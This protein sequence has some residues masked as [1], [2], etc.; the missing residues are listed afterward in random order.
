MSAVTIEL[1]KNT[2]YSIL[3]EL[4]QLPRPL[5]HAMHQLVAALDPILDLSLDSSSTNLTRNMDHKNFSESSRPPGGKKR[6]VSS[7][8]RLRPPK[9]SRNDASYVKIGSA[10]VPAVL[11]ESNEDPQ[12]QVSLLRKDSHTLN[13]GNGESDSATLC[14]LL[15]LSD[16]SDVESEEGYTEGDTSHIGWRTDGNPPSVS[17]KAKVQIMK[18]SGIHRLM[19]AT[20][21]NNFLDLVCR[22]ME[23]LT[24]DI[25]DGSL[26]SLLDQCQ[27]LE[28]K[29]GLVDLQ[30]MISL[31][32]LSLRVDL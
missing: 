29:S 6:K 11:R 24:D 23:T 22:G 20:N 31:L 17:A 1:P 3:E 12:A 27:K 25:G 21:F 8:S 5:S 15:D 16:L 10:S 4:G 14:N 30:H 32:I 13:L 18:L 7:R 2:A 19:A 9:R 28:G 26:K